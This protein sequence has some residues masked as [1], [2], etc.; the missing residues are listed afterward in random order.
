[1]TTAAPAPPPLRRNAEYRRWLVGDICLELGTGIGTFAF[2]LVTLVVTGSLGATGLV[3]MIQGI[4]G[5]AGLI[6][7]GLLADRFGRRR[8][9]LL[10]GSTGVLLQAILV[11]VLVAGWGS[12]AVLAVIAF[13]DRFR[14]A[15]LGA[16]SDA[17][18]K[19][20]VPPA[21]LA[22]AAAVNEG[23][24]AAVEMAAG[25]VGGALVGLSVVFPPLAQLLGNLGSVL[26]TWRMRGRYL[27]RAEDHAPTRVRDDLREAV[28]WTL[29]QRVR[30]QLLGVATLVNLG[31]NGLLLTVLLHLTASGVPTGR[32][33]LLNTV[34]AA[35][36]LLGAFLAPRLVDRVSTGM[37]VTAP[38][39]LMTVAGVFV[40]FAPG[41]LAIGAAY[42][43][44]GIGL[45]PLNAA[46]Q[47][48]F[49][50]ITPVS[51]QGRI[52]ALMGMVAM[53]LMPLAPAVAGWGLELTGPRPTMILFAVIIGLGA[54]V[55]LGGK[56]LRRVPVASRW[57]SYAREQG[58]S[59]GD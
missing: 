41:L 28:A 30:I 59:A 27:P 18:L 51:M 22:R 45:A 56:D 50:H 36:I 21:Q 31:M 33:G 32:V 16:A 4:G 47:G 11:A 26:A 8:L 13:L 37:L 54:L 42:A 29:S 7:G 39:L 55:V 2:P 53:G 15:L 19:Q 48:F 5:L 24:D 1:M 25:P 14:A 38:I 9:R 6:P 52:G 57:E 23:R 10:A 58:L 20:I 35:S 34:F 12:V 44:M 46:A 3:G 43:V 49:M 40:P 17:M